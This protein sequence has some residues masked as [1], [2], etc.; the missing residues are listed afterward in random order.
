MKKIYGTSLCC[1]KKGTLFDAAD[2]K[3]FA[4]TGIF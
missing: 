1:P 2:L 3:Y 4:G